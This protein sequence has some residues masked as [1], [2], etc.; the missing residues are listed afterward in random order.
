VSGSPTAAPAR[1]VPERQWPAAVLFDMDG[2]LVES[3]PIWTVAESEVTAAFGGVFTAEMKAGVIGT[4]LDVAAP[5]VVAAA[6]LAVEPAVFAE[7]LLARMVELFRADL[8]LRPG[9][10]DLLARLHA[11]G[12]PL[13]LVSSSYRLLVDAALES[14]GARYFATTVAGDEVEHGKPHPEPY[15]TAAARLGADPRECVVVE[16]SPSG[17][18]SGQAAGCVVVAVPDIVPVEPASRRAVLV[19]L[20]DLRLDEL[21]PL[22]HEAPLWR[23]PGVRA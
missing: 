22:R 10:A 12:V 7:R 23:S 2:L 20:D 8:P 9:A 4:R 19:G 11:A 5:M 6:G 14:I 13:A 21:E 3:E 15:L 1:A 18:E 17:V 16:D